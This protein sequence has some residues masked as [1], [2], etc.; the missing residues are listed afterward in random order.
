MGIQVQFLI[1]PRNAIN[2]RRSNSMTINLE[3]ARGLLARAVLT[4]GEQFVYQDSPGQSCYYRPVTEAYDSLY[5]RTSLDENSPKR[6]TACLVGVAL[7]L[8][9]ETR[10]VDLEEFVIALR[11][12]FPDMMSM[13]AAE[14]FSAAQLPQDAGKTWG[15][16]YRLAEESLTR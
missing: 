2:E 7:S 4:Q 6:K 14:Y 8:S 16:S 13:E 15:E 10:H 12:D 3:Q 9:G 1:G 5:G 11:M